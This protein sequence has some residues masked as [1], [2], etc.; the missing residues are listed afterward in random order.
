M[1]TLGLGRSLKLTLG[2]ERSLKLT[3]GLVRGF[4]DNTWISTEF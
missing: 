3:L 4:D 1:L 2:L